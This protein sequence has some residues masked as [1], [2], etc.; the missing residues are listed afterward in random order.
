MVL[1]RSLSWQMPGLRVVILS[2]GSGGRR[3]SLRHFQFC[4]ERVQNEEARALRR[5]AKPWLQQ[6]TAR[7]RAASRESGLPEELYSVKLG[8]RFLLP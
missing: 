2:D 6:L 7:V 3:R 8:L 4:C 5:S 1:G